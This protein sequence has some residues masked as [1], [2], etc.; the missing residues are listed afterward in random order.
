MS[1]S[2][3]RS[4]RNLFLGTLERCSKLII[5]KKDIVFALSN[6]PKFCYA[7]LVHLTKKLTEKSP[8]QSRFTHP[9]PINPVSSPAVWTYYLYAFTL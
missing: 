2:V 4:G 8:T 1:S 5:R 7:M 6:I 9:L 3:M